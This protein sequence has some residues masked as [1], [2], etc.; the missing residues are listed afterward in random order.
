M[1]DTSPLKERA[2]LV[3]IATRNQDLDR[4]HEYLNELAFLVE[5]AGGVPG[6]RFT[7]NLNMPT[8]E[9]M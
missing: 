3:G 8:R 9:P 6:K 4:T 1:I 5:T 2:V 7:Q